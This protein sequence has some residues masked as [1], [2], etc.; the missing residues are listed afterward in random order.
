[1]RARYGARL[2]A[3]PIVYIIALLGT[4]L[5]ETDTARPWAVLL[6]IVCAVLAVALW[7]GQDWIAAFPSDVTPKTNLN[8]SGLVYSFGVTIAVVLVLAADVRYAAAPNETF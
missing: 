8:R 1:M 7:G 5:L 3:G 2:W 6:L 4:R